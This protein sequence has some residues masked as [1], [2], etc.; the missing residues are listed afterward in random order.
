MFAKS[1]GH[2]L[3]QKVCV[4]REWAKIRDR[5]QARSVVGPAGP[6]VHPTGPPRPRHLRIQP[7]PLVMRIPQLTLDSQSVLKEKTRV[8]P[9]GVEMRLGSLTSSSRTS[10]FF[11]AWGQRP[12]VSACRSL[13][14]LLGGSSPSG[15]GMWLFLCHRLCVVCDSISAYLLVLFLIKDPAHIPPVAATVPP[16]RRSPFC[17][18]ALHKS[19]WTFGEKARE[20]GR[21]GLSG[22]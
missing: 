18:H 13:D 22:V 2:G 16:P 19:P 4:L 10:L 21:C 20:E 17:A 15:C 12:K 8:F 3:T 7:Q 9:P 6:S 5:L 11:P 14:G 1:Q